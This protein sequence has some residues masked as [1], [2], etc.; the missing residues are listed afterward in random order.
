[1]RLRRTFTASLLLVGILSAKADESAI[2]W[3][4]GRRFWAFQVPEAHA[5][6]A[7]KQSEWVRTKTDRFILARLERAGLRPNPPADRATLIRRLSFDLSGLPPTPAEVRAFVESTAP[8]ADDNL[9]SELLGRRSFGER[10]AS[11]WLNVARYAE[12][13]AHL[14]GQNTSLSYPNAYRYR[15]W[16]IDAFNRDLPYDEFIRR[17]LATDLIAPDLVAELPALGFL[18]LGH[19]YYQRSRLEVRAEEWAEKVDTLSRAFMGL[20][21]SCAQC[22]DHKYDPISM[23]DY[24]GLAGVFANLSMVNKAP[25][26]F[27]ENSKTLAKDM[28]ADTMHLVEEGGTITNLNVFARGDVTQPGPEVPRRFPRILSRGEPQL[29]RKGS[30]RLELA[31]AIADRAN[32]LTARV[33]VNRAWLAMFGRGL[34]GTPGNFGQLGDRPSHPELLDDLAVRFME[35][36]WSVKWLFRELALSAAYRQSSTTRPDGVARDEDNRLWWRM[37]RRRLAIEQF[38]DAVLAVSGQLDPR[39]GPSLDLA[40]ED[41]L[42]RTVYARVSRRELDKTLMLFDYP[43]ANVHA[44]KRSASTTAPQKLYV[45]NS[46]FVIARAKGLAARLQELADNE[47]DRIDSA[48]ALLYARAPTEAEAALGR[49][50]LAISET[51]GLTPWQQYAQALLAAN[52]MMFLD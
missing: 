33:F 12:D 3:E 36:G 42:R 28:R 20:T 38:R 31:E 21:V 39:G 15:E 19:K 5:A 1:M 11:A 17:Q 22:H 9:V 32:P 43:D 34:V 40:D 51:D 41:N 49:G 16:V 18:G 52:E 13:Q 2:D 29:F 45:L 48:F 6:P 8:D 25:D 7:V 46:P 27:H 24:Y 50:F 23:E 35:H 30:G 47:S 4:A 14:V 44:S 37:N 10:M 26:G